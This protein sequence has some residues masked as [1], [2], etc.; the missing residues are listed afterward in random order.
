MIDPDYNF[1]EAFDDIVIYAIESGDQKLWNVL[2]KHLKESEY[3]LHNDILIKHFA[4][5]IDQ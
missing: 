4:L 5:R 1:K 3:E 2:H